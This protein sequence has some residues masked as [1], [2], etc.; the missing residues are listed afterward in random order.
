MLCQNSLFKFLLSL[1][2]KETIGKI[3]LALEATY[4]NLVLA[5][6]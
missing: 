1:W 3:S 2:N 4:R 5:V 6:R